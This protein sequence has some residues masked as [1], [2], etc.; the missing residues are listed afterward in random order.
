MEWLVTQ[1]N[2]ITLLASSTAGMG[3]PL[4]NKTLLSRSDFHICT[5]SNVDNLV[6]SK[7]TKAPTASL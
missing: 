4:G 1:Y 3:W 6:T 2:I 5:A 7:T